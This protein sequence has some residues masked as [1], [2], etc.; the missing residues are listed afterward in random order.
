MNKASI[1]RMRATRRAQSVARDFRDV[2]WFSGPNMMGKLPN[3]YTRSYHA[4][5]RNAISK[6]QIIIDALLQLMHG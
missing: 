5:L 1:Q 2:D 4:S 3:V 6:T